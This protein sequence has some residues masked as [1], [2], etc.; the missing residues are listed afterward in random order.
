[1]VGLMLNLTVY[2]IVNLM[3]YCVNLKVYLMVHLMVR[4]MV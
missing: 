4:S 1:M 3:T 2:L